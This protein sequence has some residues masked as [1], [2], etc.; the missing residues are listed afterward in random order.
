MG[1]HPL[2]LLT[3]E[4]MDTRWFKDKLDDRELS[5]RVLAKLLGVHPASVNRLMHGRRPM[6][7]DEAEVVAPLLGVRVSELIERAEIDL[8]GAAAEDATTHLV[9]YID[10]AG[11]AH[12]DWQDASISVPTLPD[13][14]R[15][16]VAI[17]WR[18]AMTQLDAI[19]GWAMYVERPNGQVEHALGRLS[20]VSLE[21]DL[22]VAGFLRRGY[23]PGTYNVT[24]FFP[25]HLEN[26]RVRWASPVLLLRP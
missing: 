25:P 23:L 15:S 20:L 16:A 12:I 1:L 21:S 14:P 5:Q 9:G 19:D 3:A 26:V 13:L 2:K 8:A 10:G 7:F 24:G 17:Q 6:R 11:E 18:T 22:L 4:T